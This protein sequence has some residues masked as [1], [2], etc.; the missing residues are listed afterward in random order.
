M[1]ACSSISRS[2]V[3]S[4]PYGVRTYEAHARSA[5]LGPAR[6][7]NGRNEPAGRDGAAGPSG[8]SVMLSIFDQLFL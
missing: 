3:G 8:A 5:R 7:E 4:A 2:E 1:R 6:L